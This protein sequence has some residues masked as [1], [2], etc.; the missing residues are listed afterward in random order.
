ME[1]GIREIAKNNVLATDEVCDI[2]GITR[3]QVS[4]LVKKGKLEPLK[5]TKSENLFWKP[6]ILTMLQRRKCITTEDLHHEILGS[7]TRRAISAFYELGIDK[8]DVYEIYVYFED[9]DAIQDGF[10]CLQNEYIPDVL[11]PINAPTFVIIM[12]DGTQYWFNGLNCGYGG[13]GPNGTETVLRDLGVAEKKIETIN[14]LICVSARIHIK[15]NGTKWDIE[16]NARTYEEVQIGHKFPAHFYMYNRSIVLVQTE[17]SPQYWMRIE[18]NPIEYLQVYERYIKD[19]SQ[20]V[21]LSREDALETG[22]FVSSMG[23]TVIYQ[24]IIKDISGKELWL[25]YPVE[26]K[27]I[28]K[29]QKLI[30]MLESMG[31][32]LKDRNLPDR[33]KEWLFRTPRLTSCVAMKKGKSEEEK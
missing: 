9:M 15:R 5:T 23:F 18:E 3:Q 14:E 33:I 13:E 7:T 31:M 20:V 11:C 24:L 16:S 6:E 32:T 26:E 4:N 1:H 22:H 12:Y 10:F 30:D 8:E 2:L 27:P 29:Q 17:Y 28:Q 19:P 21:F 25:S